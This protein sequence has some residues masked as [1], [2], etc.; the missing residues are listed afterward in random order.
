MSNK[1]WLRWFLIAS[2]IGTMALLKIGVVPVRAQCGNPGPSSCTTCHTQ[3]DPVTDK[4][5]WHASHAGKDI[6]I[7]CHGG[8]GSTMDKNLAHE[9]MVAQPLSDIYTDCHSCHPDYVERAVPYAATLQITPSSCATPTPV[10]VSK[11]SNG[12]HPNSMIMPSNPVSAAPPARLFLLITGSLALLILF[13][14]C[15]C[16]LGAHQVK[17]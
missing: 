14:F 13:C 8:N 10:A 12:L 2:L 4:G 3:Q 6:C 1:V 5:A 9:G 7:N 11:V 15:A 16:W 17:N